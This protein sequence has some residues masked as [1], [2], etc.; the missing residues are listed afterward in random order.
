[1]AALATDTPIERG[2]ALIASSRDALAIS[3]LWFSDETQL[4]FARECH[5][6]HAENE[7]TSPSQALSKKQ[8]LPRSVQIACSECAHSRQGS[9]GRR[10]IG[11]CDFH[12]VSVDARTQKPLFSAKLP[13][14]DRTE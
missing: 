8:S 12:R 4:E 6:P 1:M 9:I 14:I 3:S 7:M 2:K 11:T 13:L 5:R 10:G